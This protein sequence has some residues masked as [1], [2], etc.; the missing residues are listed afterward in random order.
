MP[1]DTISIIQIT[2]THILDDGADSFDG[3]DT[4]ASLERV[5]DHINM[6]AIGA[7]LVLLTGDSVHE[8][9]VTAYQKLAGHLERLSLP[10][11]F[12]PG[13][14]DDPQRMDQILGRYGFSAGKVIQ[15]GAWQLLLLD[16]QLE[17][18]QEGA[19]SSAQLDFLQHALETGKDAYQLIALHHH[20]VT[21]NSP[22]MDA[23]GLMNADAFFRQ[24]DPYQSVKAVIWGHI[25]QQFESERNGVKLFGTPS[26]CLQFTPLSHSFSVDTRPPGYRRLVLG[27]N[28]EI[29]TEVIYI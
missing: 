9:T 11:Y 12:L 7:E 1:A 17:N 23:M 22:W 24:L 25:H 3:F 18:K 16:T 10:V 28:G 5:I 27:N 29:R 20:P 14:H 15:L 26:T 4:S 13:N 6:N 21:I 8:P 19:L 2:D